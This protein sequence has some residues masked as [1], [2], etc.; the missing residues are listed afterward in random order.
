MV[1]VTEISFIVNHSDFDEFEKMSGVS[2]SDDFRDLSSDE[3]S[4][5]FNGKERR[6]KKREKRDIET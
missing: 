2:L 4:A 5:V 3:N 1:H 6:K